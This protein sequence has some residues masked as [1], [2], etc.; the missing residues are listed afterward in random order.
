MIAPARAPSEATYASMWRD[1]R[2]RLAW[3]VDEDAYALLAAAIDQVEWASRALEPLQQWVGYSPERKRPHDELGALLTFAEAD[4]L[5]VFR[6]V[7]NDLVEVV[8]TWPGQKGL[9]PDNDVNAQL[10]AFGRYASVLTLATEAAAHVPE[11]FR[12]AVRQV[13]PLLPGAA[14]FLRTEEAFDHLK[15]VQES[16]LNA[17]WAREAVDV[18]VHAIPERERGRVGSLVVLDLGRH[19]AAAGQPLPS[20][21]VNLQ[22]HFTAT[23]GNE[24]DE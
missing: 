19:Y 3:V 9:R 8:A 13:A 2:A 12:D 1:A 10:T 14:W 6:V 24:G 11:G 21:L 18:L 16:E 23:T 7:A 15:D 20:W 4:V 22:A 5:E 17:H